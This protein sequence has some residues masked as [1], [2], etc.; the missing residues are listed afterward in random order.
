VLATLGG[1]AGDFAVEAATPDAPPTQRLHLG[2]YAPSHEAV[3]AFWQAGI[4][5]GY[6][7]DGAPGPR[8][9]YRDDYYGGFL[10]DPDGNS[11]EA[12]YL[13]DPGTVGQVDHVWV[14]VADVAAARDRHR[15]TFERAGFQLV[16]DGPE[17]AGFR[18]P[19]AAFSFVAGEP[20]EHVVV[21]LGGAA[22]VAL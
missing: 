11:A 3:Q 5:A 2:F 8:P 7:D 17:R 14:R 15:A 18:R 1:G 12:V 19:G 22:V 21:A 16:H 6:R 10:L 9:V 4:D 20:T 13:D